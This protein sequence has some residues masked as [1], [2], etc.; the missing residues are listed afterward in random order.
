MFIHFSHIQLNIV[1]ITVNILYYHGRNLY[2]FLNSMS[3]M[4]SRMLF[5]ISVLTQL[6]FCFIFSRKLE[7]SVCWDILAFM[8]YHIRCVHHVFFPIDKLIF[9]EQKN[10][11][12]QGSSYLIF[13]GYFLANMMWMLQ[14]CEKVEYECLRSI[15]S[16]DYNVGALE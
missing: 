5:A 4:V 12:W 16:Y 14:Y 15:N 13:I 10:N 11:Y 6:T 2:F 1:Y 3:L 9:T 7:W 8:F